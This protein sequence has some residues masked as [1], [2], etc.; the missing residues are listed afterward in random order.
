M[1]S[2]LALI[3]NSELRDVKFQN[4]VSVLVEA[5]MGAKLTVQAAECP[6]QVY[7]LLAS[8]LYAW[9]GLPHEN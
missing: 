5:R 6:V 3:G 2:T 7:Q 4:R 8:N 9:L 1:K